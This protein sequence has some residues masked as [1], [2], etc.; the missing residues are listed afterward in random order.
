MKAPEREKVPVLC[1]EHDLRAAMSDDDFWAHVYPQGEH[2]DEG[3][4]LL[5]A[6]DMVALSSIDTPCS[7]CGVVGACA[8]DAEGRALIHVTEED[9]A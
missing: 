1:P 2:E 9:D 3:P 4:N 8:Y 6:E 5:D 7:E